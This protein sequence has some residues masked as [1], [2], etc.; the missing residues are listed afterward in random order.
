MDFRD[1]LS[2]GRDKN[3]DKIRVYVRRGCLLLSVHINIV[4]INIFHFRRT[5]F[6]RSI[7]FDPPAVRQQIF[8]IITTYTSI[9]RYI[10][11]SVKFL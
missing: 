5:T 10:V 2:F 1:E 7:L 6:I 3:N 4:H 11:L 8:P 9:T